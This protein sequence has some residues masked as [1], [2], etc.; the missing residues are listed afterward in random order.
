MEILKNLKSKTSAISYA[1]R[2][3]VSPPLRSHLKTRPKNWVLL[4][5]II[6][7]IIFFL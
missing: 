7:S 4:A 1:V 2:S 6:T 3:P 5:P